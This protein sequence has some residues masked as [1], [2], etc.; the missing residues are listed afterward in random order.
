MR[1]LNKYLLLFLIID[2]VF[3]VTCEC[4]NI[5][6]NEW[7]AGVSS[8]DITPSMPMWMAG[9]GSRTKP[10]NEVAHPLH[11]KALALKDGSGK[12]ALIITLDILG[13]PANLRKMVEEHVSEKYGIDPSYLLM[14]YSHTHSGPEVRSIETSLFKRDPA[15]TELVNKYRTELEEKILKVTG[16]AFSHMA[17]VKL[18]YGKAKAGFAM[19]RRMDYS[20]PEDDPGYGKAPSS[21][22]PVDH[23]V[24]VL[25]VT[26]ADGKLIAVIFSYACHATNIGNYTFHGDYPGFAQHYLEES[27]KGATAL[28]MAGCGADQN[29]HPRGDMVNG[30]NGLDLAKMHGRTLAL[31]VEAAL[32]S[33][34]QPVEPQLESIL[35]TASLEYLTAPSHDELKKRTEAKDATTRENALVLLEWMERDGKLP[36]SY[37]YPVQVIRFGKDLTIVALASEVVVDYSLRLKRELAGDVWVTA[38]SNDFL[39]YIPSLR[40]WSEGG[41]EGGNSLTFTSTTL[42][43]GAAHPDIWA[44]TVEKTI[45]SKVHEINGKIIDKL[46]SI[47]KEKTT[48]SKD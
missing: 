2:L 23:D 18:G 42:Y 4:Q 10:G 17:P 35:E 9:Y 12:V 28:F 34:P 47:S 46:N 29:P 11:A 40:I 43:R 33:H 31:A 24:P 5:D 48:G 13:V 22:G 6:S 30:F 20:L 7:Q 25:Q 41:Y 19:N 15:R 26:G 1:N 37:Q 14:S 38:Y 44:P 45:I 21:S 3:P 8:I 32:N 27:H 16:D 36:R 39:G